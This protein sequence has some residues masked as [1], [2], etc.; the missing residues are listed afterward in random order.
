MCKSGLVGMV[1]CKGHE[2]DSNWGYSLYCLNKGC[3][4]QEVMGHGKNEKE[5]YEVIHA[6]FIGRREEKK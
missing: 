3:S 5:A 2:E 4:A 1:G 6:K